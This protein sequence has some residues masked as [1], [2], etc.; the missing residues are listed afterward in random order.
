MNQQRVAIIKLLDILHYI[1]ALPITQRSKTLNCVTRIGIP[2][3]TQAFILVSLIMPIVLNLFHLQKCLILLIQKITNI[4]PNTIRKG[5]HSHLNRAIP[6]TTE[7]SRNH[8]DFLI[9]RSHNY[10]NP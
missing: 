1:T 6:I 5:Y 7:R 9:Y 2:F 8:K 4:L 10:L 3:N